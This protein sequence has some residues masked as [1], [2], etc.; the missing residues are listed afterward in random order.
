MAGRYP[1]KLMGIRRNAV[2]QYRGKRK[3]YI[4]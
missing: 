2:P 3:N 4:W 1:K